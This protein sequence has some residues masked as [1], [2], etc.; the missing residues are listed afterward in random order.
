MDSKGNYNQTRKITDI[1]FLVCFVVV[2]VVVD[3]LKSL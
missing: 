2:V 3:F 1:S